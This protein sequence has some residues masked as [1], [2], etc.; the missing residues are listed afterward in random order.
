MIVFLKHPPMST[1]MQEGKRVFGCNGALMV[2]EYVCQYACSSK[3][4]KWV[5][6]VAVRV[7][8]KVSE[9]VSCPTAATQKK[10]SPRDARVKYPSLGGFYCSTPAT[11]KQQSPRDAGGYIRPLSS[12]YST[13]TRATPG[14]KS[15]P[16][17]VYIVRY[18]PRKKCGAPGTPRHASHPLAMN[19][20]PCL[21]GKKR[22][23]PMPTRQKKAEPAGRQGGISDP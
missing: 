9:W 12:V 5:K 18:L 13:R 22:A 4:S 11:Q 17:A 23:E 16:L 14:R 21:P 6:W 1:E 8:E 2:G 3:V 15:D 20:V 19:I 7:R 10:R